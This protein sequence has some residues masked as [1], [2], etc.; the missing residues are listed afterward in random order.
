MKLYF[1]E[2]RKICEKKIL[3]VGLG[4]MFLFFFFQFWVTNI[5]DYRIYDNGNVY[6]GI[7][8]IKRDQEIAREYEGALTFERAEQIIDRYG[9]SYFNDMDYETGNFCSRFITHMTTH[10]MQNGEKPVE[11]VK[12]KDGG[13]MGE[14]WMDGSLNFGY[15]QGWENLTEGM[16]LYV[17]GVCLLLIIAVSPVFCEE[18]M[19]G[20]ADI[21]YTTK[22]GRGKDIWMKIA[23]ALGVSILLYT[24]VVGGM[25]LAYFCLYGRDGLSASAARLFYSITADRNKTVLS[26]FAEYFITGLMGVLLNTCMT[27]FISSLCRQNFFSVILSV[28]CYLAPVGVGNVVLSMF[29]VTKVTMILRNICLWFPFYLSHI[30]QFNRIAFLEIWRICVITG[31]FCVSIVGAYRVYRK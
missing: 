26:F 22:H 29:P 9:F 10:L 13:Y 28:I 17:T 5:G 21:A 25:Y 6:T 31:L 12:N 8:A 1:M 24:V 16:I 30:L 3:W 4:A 14:E 11:F 2:M 7:D 23:A 20:T 15:T 18:Y 27:L 19:L